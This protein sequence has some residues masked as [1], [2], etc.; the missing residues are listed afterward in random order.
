MLLSN[1][2]T[3]TSFLITCVYGST[4][5]SH[6]RNI[7]QVL[8]NTSTTNLPWCVLGDF[9]A[10]LAHNEKLSLRQAPPS[11]LKGFQSVVFQVG[12]FDIRFSGSKFTWSNNRKGLSYVAARLDRVLVNTLQLATFPYPTTHHLLRLS[13]DHSPILLNHTSLLPATHAPIKFENKWLLHPSF[14]QLVSSN[15]EIPIARNPQFILA[16]KLK[17]LK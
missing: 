7:W 4:N 2:I 5:P 16:Q 14:M 17:A 3:G 12:L 11:S 10:T 8:I 13:S 9:N 15:W 1:R 6:R